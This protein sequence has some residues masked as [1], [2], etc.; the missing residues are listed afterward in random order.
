VSEYRT[1]DPAA[2]EML[3]HTAGMNMSTQFSR[4][5]AQQPQ[6]KFGNTGICCK[7]CIQG[8]CR[9]IPKK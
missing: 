9:I 6:C 4:Y 7:I 5:L 8:P 1:A 3:E 2:L